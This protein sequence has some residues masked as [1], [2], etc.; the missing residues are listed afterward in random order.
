MGQ[1][2]KC[3]KRHGNGS[4]RLLCIGA[5]AICVFTVVSVIKRCGE[6]TPEPIGYEVI[7]VHGGDTLWGI[8]SEFCPNG[9]DIRDYIQTVCR[10]NGIDANIYPGDTIRVPVYTTE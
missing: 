9:K 1:R 7:T 3:R 2:Q 10:E 5:A 8:A 6:K 4:R